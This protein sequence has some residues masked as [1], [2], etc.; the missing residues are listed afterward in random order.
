MEHIFSDIGKAPRWIWA[1]L[2]AWFFVLAVIV[3]SPKLSPVGQAW[4]SVLDFGLLCAF[5]APVVFRAARGNHRHLLTVVVWTFVL[6][7]IGI[8]TA[9]FA[10]YNLAGVDYTKY[11]KIL[12]VVPVFVAIWAAAVG[13]L[14]H[15]KLTNKSHRT[16]NAFSII[17]ETRKSPEYL[18]RV[19][20][21]AKHFPPGTRDIPQGYEAYFDSERISQALKSDD[22]VAKERAEAVLALK[23]ILNYFEFMAVGIRV[24][25]LDEDLIFDT[26][27]TTVCS[28]YA[29][30]NRYIN[31]SCD[32]GNAGSH[33]QTYCELKTLV[34]KWKRWQAE[35]EATGAHGET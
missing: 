24:G 34:P 30:A 11:D 31:Y 4:A 7:I 6:I 12:N 25:D 3:L 15:F 33:R 28:L 26:V 32:E 16:N 10:F 21:I 20:L 5:F 17:M 9:F 29:R 35:I 23:Y 8:A 13:W 1:F 14:I 22:D 18:A 27:N 19:K 2:I